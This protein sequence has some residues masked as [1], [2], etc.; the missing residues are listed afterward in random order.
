[1]ACRS[2]AKCR[3][4]ASQSRLSEQRE[5][6]CDGPLLG[7]TRTLLGRAAMSANEP[8]WTSV[9]PLTALDRRATMPGPKPR[10]RAMRRRELVLFL[11]SANAGM[12][13]K[14]AKPADLP[15]V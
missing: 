10:G 7:A 4:E 15:Q 14:G 2:E 9:H 1:M 8:K 11:G 6:S 13:L 3:F 12:I 5:A